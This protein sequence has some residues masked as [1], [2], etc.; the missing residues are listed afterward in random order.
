MNPIDLA[1]AT[2]PAVS[3]VPSHFMV[4]GATYQRGAELGFEG[5]DFYTGGRG[6]VLGDVHG[7]V[8]AAAFVFFEPSQVREGWDRAGAVTDRATAAA[9]FAAC[10]YQWA[11][12][13][14]TGEE[15]DVVAEL[16]A[17]VVDA[18][19]PA[20]TPVF[21]AWRLLPVPT[22]RA[23]AAF[24]QLN[25]LRE[26][27]NAMHGAAIL[28]AGLTP[29]EAVAVRARRWLRSSDGRAAAGRRA[30]A[31]LVQG[32]GRHRRRHGARAVRA[33]RRRGRGVR[34]GVR[35]AARIV[36]HGPLM[37]AVG[38]GTPG[39]GLP[40]R[41]GGAPP[42]AREVDALAACHRRAERRL[43]PAR[44]RDGHRRPRRRAV[45]RS[46]RRPPRG[47]QAR[48]AGW[49]SRRTPRTRWPGRWRWWVVAPACASSSG[50]R[51]EAGWAA[52]PPTPP[53]SCA[54]R[55]R[56]TSHERRRSARTCPSAS[57]VAG[58]GSPGWARSSSRSR[59]NTPGSRLLTPPFGCSTPAV[60]RAWDDLGGPTA[61][62]PERPRAGGAAGRATT[63]RLAGPAGGGHGRDPGPCRKWEH[64]VRAGLVPGD[65]RVVVR[66]TGPLT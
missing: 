32:R 29:V 66:T 2:G 11:R 27:R 19:S 48:R 65:G 17:K 60:Y 30:R 53:R 14:L 52:G 13:H 40:E 38:V 59:S 44:R 10:G 24:H 12:R 54:G 18:A 22:D 36:D 4:E 23:A 31:A 42:G 43:P 45:A 56:P 49:T 63:R 20:L 64:V 47:R 7:D 62:G 3:K 26:L 41:G 46:G 9:E 39:W 8:V 51:P 34:Q 28:T 37:D 61:D 25:A 50:S 33:L 57:S 16:G 21:A 15:L 55:V 1:S 35:R 58:R 5:A 6:G